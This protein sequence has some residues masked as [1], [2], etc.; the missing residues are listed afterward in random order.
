M[1]RTWVFHLE[2][3]PGNIPWSLD[4]EISEDP[5]VTLAMSYAVG[6]NYQGYRI[7]GTAQKGRTLTVPRQHA[8]Q[9]DPA[10]GGPRLIMEVLSPPDPVNA[11]YRLRRWS[12]RLHGHRNRS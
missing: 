2:T 1:T 4:K 11:D 7:V 8:A 6:D 5:R 10:V 9:N 3:S 12:V